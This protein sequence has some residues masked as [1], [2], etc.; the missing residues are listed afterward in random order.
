[1]VYFQVQKWLDP[2]TYNFSV[3]MTVPYNH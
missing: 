1:V 3:H 2:L